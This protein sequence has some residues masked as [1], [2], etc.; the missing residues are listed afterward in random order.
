MIVILSLPAAAGAQ[1]AGT[2]QTEAATEPRSNAFVEALGGWGA[3][4]GATQYLPD[5]SPTSFEHPMVTGWSAG[6]T[7]GWLFMRD[8]ALT[9][10]YEY[11][12]ATSVTGSIE[13]A[14][15]SVQG[16]VTYHTAVLGV[17][18]YRALGPGRMR[19]EL[20]AGIALPFETQTEYQWGPALEPAGVTGEGTRTD[21]YATGFGVAGHIGYEVAVGG[22]AFVGAALSVRSFQSNNNG[23]KTELDN[24]VTDLTAPMATTATIE[25]GD[26]K[27]QP[28]TYS[29]QDVGLRLA[30]GA[31]F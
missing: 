16:S 21:Q 26:D 22:P 28:E 8:L 2:V 9:G 19:A 30:V 11:R 3:Q 23:E 12:T 20:G 24:V 18:M 7:V 6:A 25:Y 14:I 13:G 29:V 10:T 5:G 4:F 1:E 15:D 27:A 17:R 31:R